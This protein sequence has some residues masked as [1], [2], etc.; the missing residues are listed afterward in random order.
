[1]NHRMGGS[2]QVTMT[3][4]GPRAGGTQWCRDKHTPCTT[5]KVPQKFIVFDYPYEMRSTVLIWQM[6][7]C[8]GIQRKQ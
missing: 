2:G 7:E 6:K 5:G 8:T 1:M 4:L 3:L